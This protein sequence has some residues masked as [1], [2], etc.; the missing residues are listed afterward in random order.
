MYSL[1][2]PYPPS[3]NHYLGRGRRGVYLT[4]EARAFKDEAAL[5]G[6]L[7]GIEP[8]AGDLAVALGM[9]RPRR[10][11]DIDGIIKLALD[12]MNGVAWVDDRQV[13]E[14]HVYRYDD[15]RNPRLELVVWRKE[16]AYE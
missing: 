2:L 1:T 8:L 7:A 5:I 10:S 11:G 9:Y 15:R 14:L 3:V 4:P 13:V 6:R 16:K 12:C